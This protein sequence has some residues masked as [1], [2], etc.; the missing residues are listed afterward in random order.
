[1]DK[2]LSEINPKATPGT[3]LASQAAADGEPRRQSTPLLRGS[4][5]AHITI[6]PSRNSQSC[7]PAILATQ[8]LS[9][10]LPALFAVTV[11]TSDSN[12]G[13]YSFFLSFKENA[14]WSLV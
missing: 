9:Q 7:N 14:R 1:M 5:V 13:R 10:V 11:R 2:A 6:C 8:P 3:I 4:A 12:N